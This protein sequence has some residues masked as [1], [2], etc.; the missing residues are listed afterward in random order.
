MSSVF[1]PIFAT[2]TLVATANYLLNSAVGKILKREIEERDRQWLGADITIGG[3]KANV[4]TGVV[5]LKNVQ[6]ENPLRFRPQSAGVAAA[7]EGCR[8]I[9]QQEEI[10]SNSG[11]ADDT[12]SSE[13][14]ENLPLISVNEITFDFEMVKLL[15]KNFCVEIEELGLH[16]VKINLQVEGD[17]WGPDLLLGVSN[18]SVLLEE[19]QERCV[20][21]KG[22]WKKD[23]SATPVINDKVVTRDV[24]KNES[25]TETS[26]SDEVAPKK[27]DRK[28][29]LRKVDFSDIECE[30]DGKR[31]NV[32]DIK[33]DDFYEE[34]GSSCI[35]DI[36]SLLLESLLINCKNEGIA[37]LA[38]TSL[39][40]VDDGIQ[41]L[42]KF[43]RVLSERVNSMKSLEAVRRR[44]FSGESRIVYAEG[45]S[46]SK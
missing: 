41:E 9:R 5:V 10:A 13:E 36:C 32:A 35:D 44:A 7:I 28:F 31:V 40:V 26:K 18:V 3:I 20:R 25:T 29:Y 15:R 38:G 17:V 45:S 14:D 23:T 46:K 37:S 2:G 27:R 43:G 4:W 1:Q 19:I 12:R 16:G 30:Y 39:K 22:T 21:G 33:Y 34:V 42:T 24:V 6:L 11:K 8:E